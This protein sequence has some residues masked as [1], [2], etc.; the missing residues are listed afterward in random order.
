VT[1]IEPLY[2]SSER[3]NDLARRAV[4]E[5]DAPLCDFAWEIEGQPHG[6]CLPPG[7]DDEHWCSCEEVHA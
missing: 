6:C 4:T 2:D 5:P 3:F 7:H 1:G